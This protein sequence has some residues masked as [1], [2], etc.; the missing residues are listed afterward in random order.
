MLCSEL[1][2]AGHKVAVIKMDPLCNL[3]RS[4]TTDLHTGKITT[5]MQGVYDRVERM[6]V[7]YRI[8]RDL[9]HIS[10]KS[11]NKR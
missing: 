7:E 2:C 1:L 10:T 11:V 9:R 8:I 4:Q 5:M 6:E 3:L